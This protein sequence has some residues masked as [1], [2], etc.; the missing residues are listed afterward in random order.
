[1]F[2]ED[3]STWPVPLL[4]STRNELIISKMDPRI[5]ARTK[6]TRLFLKKHM[7]DFRKN[8][9][10]FTRTWIRLSPSTNS[11]LCLPCSVYSNE[12]VS[13][14][15]KIGNGQIGFTDFRH[16]T[17]AVRNHEESASHLESVHRWKVH[18]K[19]S[20]LTV[21]TVDFVLKAKSEQAEP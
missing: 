1:M 10:M 21:K 5:S 13:P 12:A 9:E 14:W 11:A 15:T 3:P 6:A 4:N 18:F 17:R 19:P 7:T 2:Y 20:I 8:G 16:S